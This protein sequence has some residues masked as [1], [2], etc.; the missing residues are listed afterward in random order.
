M[1]AGF[2][3]RN[4]LSHPASINTMATQPKDYG[5]QTMIQPEDWAY[6]GMARPN[7]YG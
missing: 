6:P 1:M 7:G 2:G 3:L 5:C 4:N